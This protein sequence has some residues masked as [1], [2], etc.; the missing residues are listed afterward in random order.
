M[1]TSQTISSTNR[2]YCAN[3]AKT[4][5]RKKKKFKTHSEKRRLHLRTSVKRLKQSRIQLIKYEVS[6]AY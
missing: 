1:V 6:L 3:M 4:N 5:A 2:L